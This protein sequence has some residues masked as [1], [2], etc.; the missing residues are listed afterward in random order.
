MT[1]VDANGGGIADKYVELAID[2]FARNGAIIVGA[3]GLTT[4]ANGQ[5]VFKVQVDE[6]ARDGNYDAATF[7]AEDLRLTAKFKEEGFI[8]AT[9]VTQV[10]I[11]QAAVQNPIAS[12]VIRSK[13]NGSRVHRVM[14]FITPRNLSVSVVDFDGKPLANQVVTLDYYT[15]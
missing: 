8:D 4:H 6:R 13:S 2:N 7:A 15:Y 11:V 3:S 5:A 10:D 12:I 1:L 14:E 9:Q